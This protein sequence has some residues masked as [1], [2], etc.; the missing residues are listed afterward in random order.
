[1]S[2]SFRGWLRSCRLS[3]VGHFGSCLLGSIFDGNFLGDFVLL[4]FSRARF[5][6]KLINIGL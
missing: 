1:M 5:R 6:L 2:V 3:V 4:G